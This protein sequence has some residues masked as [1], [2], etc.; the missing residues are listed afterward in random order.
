MYL[1]RSPEPTYKSTLPF[2]VMM[3]FYT[4]F[5]IAHDAR[6]QLNAAPLNQTLFQG[7][8][9]GNN[10]FLIAST[11]P[12]NDSDGDH[13]HLVA[14]LNCNAYSNCNTT[15]DATFGNRG[16]FVATYSA[17]GA[18]PTGLDVHLVAYRQ[19]DSSTNIYI[20][21]G[22]YYVSATY[23]VLANAQET[24]YTNPTPNAATPPGTLVFDSSSSQYPPAFYSNFAGQLSTAGVIF[25]D[26]SQLA[27]A[28]GL[29]ALAHAAFVNNSGYV[30]IGTTTPMAQLDVTGSSGGLL[31]SGANLDPNNHFPVSGL[32]NSDKL[33]LGWN[34]TA[35]PG[36]QDFF[37]NR[38]PGWAGGF[39]FYDVDNTGHI[40]QLLAIGGPSNSGLS[41][42]GNI[43][44]AA[45]SGAS[46]TFSDNTVQATAWNGVL[47]GGDYAE[48][49]SITGDLTEYEPGDVLV[50]DPTFEGRFAKSMKAYSTAAIGIYSTKPGL[51]GRRQKTDRSHMSEEIP[52]AMIGIVP[53]KVTTE[54]GQIHPGDLLVTSSTPGY[55][56]R[57]TDRS[58]MTGAI[59]GK[60][61]GHL[62]SGTGLIEVAVSLQ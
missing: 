25:P 37:G 41:V 30:G 15:L 36:E 28:Y 62:D 49:V 20:F 10:Y 23:S 50:V 31:V 9:A 3:V 61:L 54:G 29:A 26:G 12:D 7:Q 46:I 13:M 35:G 27:S 40:T 43:K 58:Q 53:T 2:V 47:Q 4:F 48:S 51:V 59:I 1:S 19:P 52:M 32:Q 55:A 21:L 11:P 56:M 16:G 8:G 24:I 14:T 57:G 18:S 45:Q 38:G 34:Y 60:A 17:Q 33:L 22:D 42:S 44:L 39:N 6:A 5:G